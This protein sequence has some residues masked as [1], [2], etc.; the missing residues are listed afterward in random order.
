MKKKTTLKFTSLPSQLMPSKRGS[1]LRY[2]DARDLLPSRTV[3]DDTSDDRQDWRLQCGFGGVAG[4]LHCAQPPETLFPGLWNADGALPFRPNRC[5]GLSTLLSA[6]PSNSPIPCADSPTSARNRSLVQ[7]DMQRNSASSEATSCPL[8]SGLGL[9]GSRL[10]MPASYARS[11]AS[12]PCPSR[13][14]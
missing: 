7:H 9:I 4:S 2:Q 14:C 5:L 8:V 11:P 1:S 13:G 12:L 3:H 10:R 6:P